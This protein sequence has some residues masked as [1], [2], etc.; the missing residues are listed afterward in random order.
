LE[1]EVVSNEAA[2]PSTEGREEDESKASS[3]SPYTTTN[4]L[5]QRVQLKEQTLDDEEEDDE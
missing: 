2:Q 5:L 3:V 4:T 1:G